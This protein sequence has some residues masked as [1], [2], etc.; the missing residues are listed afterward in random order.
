MVWTF[1]VVGWG[2]WYLGRCCCCHCWQWYHHHCH[3][4]LGFLI[5]WQ[6]LTTMTTSCAV[7][8]HPLPCKKSQQPLFFS[9][10][11]VGSIAG[12]SCW[13]GRGWQAHVV[14]DIGE[15]WCGRFLLGSQRPSDYSL[16]HSKT[17]VVDD[18]MVNRPPTATEN[19]LK[20]CMVGLSNKARCGNATRQ[21]RAMQQGGAGLCNKVGQGN[22][23]RWGGATQQGGTWQC[24]EAGWGNE[25]GDTS[26]GGICE[27]LFVC[28]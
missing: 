24:N 7:K 4:L 23:M 6:E 15:C 18:S 11:V 12:R 21:G 17:P 14:Q 26:M 20:A 5:V 22:V 2:S 9:H 3:D 1:V 8:T 13:T 19:I 10:W 16:N 28:K 27:K 25:G